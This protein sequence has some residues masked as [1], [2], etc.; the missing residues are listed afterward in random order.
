MSDLVPQVGWLVAFTAGVFSFVSPCVLPLVPGYLS[1]VSGVSLDATTQ[2]NR[3]ETVRILKSS[4]LF[5]SG[6]SMVFIVLGASFSLVGSFFETY[7]KPLTIAAGAVMVGMG[8]VVSGLLSPTFL[9]REL[10]FHPRNGSPSHGGTLLLGM[11]FA[12]GWTPCI[13]PVLASILF[14]AAAATTMAQ[15]TA[16]L[17]LYSLGLAIPFVA[18]GIFFSRALGAFSWV[19]RHYNWIR[20]VNGGLLVG[21]GV[22][23]LTGKVFYFSLMFQKLYY[24]WFY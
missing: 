20:L 17:S 10:K 23:F 11:A 3:G 19:R 14:Y 22:L 2:R 6:F 18:T 24:K 5:V 9:N 8:L 12:F 7:R 16:L 21:V 13:G 4:L 15:G 1:Y